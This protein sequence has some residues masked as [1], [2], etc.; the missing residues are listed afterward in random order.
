MES[1]GSAFGCF[2][3]RVRGMVLLGAWR[4]TMVTGRVDGV[5]GSPAVV[6]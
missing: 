5:R 4:L 3:G 1:L 2:F 6:L